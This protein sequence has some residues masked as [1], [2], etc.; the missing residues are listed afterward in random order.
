M[1]SRFYFVSLGAVDLW[2]LTFLPSRENG[3]ES[4]TKSRCYLC[5]TP[6]VSSWILLPVEKTVK[7]KIIV[8]K[9]APGLSGRAI[10]LVSSTTYLTTAAVVARAHVLR[11]SRP[12]APCRGRYCLCRMPIVQR[13]D[14]LLRVSP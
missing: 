14:R 2:M 9:A 13:N 11:T 1:P 5:K 6:S 12:P 10:F 3:R 7:I 4:K 8:A